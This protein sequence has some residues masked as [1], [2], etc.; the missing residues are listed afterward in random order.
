MDS[1]LTYTPVADLWA[2][3]VERQNS[4]RDL[5]TSERD[6]LCLHLQLLRAAQAVDTEPLSPI[7]IPA[8]HVHAL[9]Q[10]LDTE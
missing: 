7:N 3:N 5:S 9:L 1:E 2:I 4:G 10:K 8:D 6:W